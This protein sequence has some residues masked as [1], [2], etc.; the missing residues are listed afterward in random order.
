MVAVEDFSRL[1]SSIYE[2]AATPQHWELAIRDVQSALGGTGGSLLRGDGAVWSLHDS[3]IPAPAIQSYTDYYNRSDYVLAAMRTA[4]V[5]VVQ[6]GPKVVVP[7][8]DPEFYTGW[9]RPNELEDGLFVRLTGDPQ[10]TCF[11]IASSKVGFDTAD[12]VK[13]LG[14]LVGHLQQALRT[15]DRLA[16]LADSVIEM[17][18][19]LDVVR[20]GVVVV[21]RES[22]VVNLNSA[23]ENIFR[24]DDGLCSVAGRIVATSPHCD[25]QLHIA[26][27]DAVV[28]D[29]SSVR[30]GGS[31]ICDRPSAK[32][33]YLVHVLPSHRSDGDDAAGRPMG[34]LLIIDPEDELEPASDLLRRLYKLT[35]AEAEIALH[36]VRGADP[37]QVAD[38]LSVS[39]ATVRTHLHHVFDKT[40]THR[41]AEL[42]RLLLALCP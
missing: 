23:A 11:L 38:E 32:R 18:G 35:E 9:M 31:F 30:T 4:D 22:V 29:D 33:P 26:I 1:V 15:T 24:A 39:L 14:G 21:A 17:A 28:G 27:R 41:Q 40:R 16:A 36:M 2:A 25:E 20:H 7:N 13:L 37:M 3:T 12:R 5:G 42:V 19:A 6:T 8:R 10:P 34:L